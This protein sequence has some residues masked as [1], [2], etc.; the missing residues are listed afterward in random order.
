MET[1]RKTTYTLEMLHPNDLQSKTI[2]RPGLRIERM[3]TPFPEFNKFLHTVV[4]YPHLWGGREDWSGEDWTAYASRDTLQTWVAYVDGTPAGYC[5]MEK[6]PQGDVEIMCFGLL[7]VFI[8]QGLGGHLLTVAVER[9]WA[10]TGNGGMGATRV[11]LHTC[12][13]DHPHAL[14][15]YLA[16][17]FRVCKTE[18]EPANDPIPSFWELT[19]HPRAPKEHT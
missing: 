18:E 11:W 10:A 2:E 19:T 16:R 7:P 8:G 1:K 15:N 12:T 17:G 6:G 13:H 14:H 9:A 5:E 4:G 3:T